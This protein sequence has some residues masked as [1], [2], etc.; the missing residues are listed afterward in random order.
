[1]SVT[2]V[3]F[4]DEPAL[5]HARRLR[6]PQQSTSSTLRRDLSPIWLFGDR[7]DVPTS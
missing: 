5:R 1:M 4:D 3:I 7:A 6:D 2:S